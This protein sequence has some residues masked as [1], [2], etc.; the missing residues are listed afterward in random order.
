MWL[1][2]GPKLRLQA[3]RGT[4][5]QEDDEGVAQAKFVLRKVSNPQG[6]S[7]LGKHL[8]SQSPCFA[9]SRPSLRLHNNLKPE[10]LLWL[11][12]CRC[13]FCILIRE[14]FEHL[15]AYSQDGMMS[16]LLHVHV[17]FGGD[18]VR[19]DPV[20]FTTNQQLVILTSSG[21]EKH[22]LIDAD[23]GPHEKSA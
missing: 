19:F 11:S 3:M 21:F 15:R 4:A 7:N 22:C 9:V 23:L 14:A 5:C 6:S 18:V 16:S 8:T 2:S 1:L 13:G 17:H 10:L 12:S 20:A